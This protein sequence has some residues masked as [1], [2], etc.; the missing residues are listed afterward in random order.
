MPSNDTIIR[1]DPANQKI[2]TGQEIRIS[3]I[4]VEE[5]QVK[6]K[7]DFPTKVLIAGEQGPAGPPGN[8]GTGAPL[9]G[10]CGVAIGAF[11]AVCLVGGLLYPADTTNTS[12]A[13][14]FVG[15]STQSGLAGSV[16]EYIQFGDLFSGSFSPGDRYYIGTNGFLSTI[17]AAGATWLKVMGVGKT[18]STIVLDFG[19]TFI[20]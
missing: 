15:V 17:R 2:S 6:V 1:L 19:P 3:R 12:L 10:I 13:P 9:Q 20:L 7:Y 18:A 16:V 5:T 11:Q 4:N 14:F 8:S